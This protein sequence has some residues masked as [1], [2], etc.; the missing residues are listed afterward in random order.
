MNNYDLTY[1]KEHLD[2]YYQTKEAYIMSYDEV[3]KIYH[4]IESLNNTI[5]ELDTF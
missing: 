1:L 2:T 3:D 5:N 4:Y